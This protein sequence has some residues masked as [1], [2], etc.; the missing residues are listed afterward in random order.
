MAI[1]KNLPVDMIIVEPTVIDGEHI[2]AGF[3]IKKCETS[4]AMDLASSGKARPA[5]D[6]LIA[7]F[8]ARAKAKAAAEAA[9]KEREA[10]AATAAL[11]G[12]EALASVIGNAIAAGVQLAVDKL[13]APAETVDA[14]GK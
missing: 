8:K 1:D 3:V 14:G 12:N 2:E 13:A 5:T 11:A 10:N 9:A 4:L 7:E 6:D